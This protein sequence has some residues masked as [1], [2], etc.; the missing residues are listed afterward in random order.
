MGVVLSWASW[1]QAV[2]AAVAVDTV[3]NFP[4]W[5]PGPLDRQHLLLLFHCQWRGRLDLQPP[6]QQPSSHCA[7]HSSVPSYAEYP[8]RLSAAHLSAL[9]IVQYTV[10]LL[11]TLAGYVGNE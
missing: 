1:R 6:T 3:V 7:A 11:L 2:V 4:G 10:G 8:A 5:H 9:F